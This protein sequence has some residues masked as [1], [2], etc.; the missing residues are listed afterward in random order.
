VWILSWEFS[1][2]HKYLHPL[3]QV[4]SSFVDNIDQNNNLDIFEMVANINELAKKIF[5]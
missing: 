2:E 1:K 4:E 3:F 5:N